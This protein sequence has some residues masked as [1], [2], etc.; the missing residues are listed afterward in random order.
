MPNLG[1]SMRLDSLIKDWEG[2]KAKGEKDRR[3]W[4]SQ[5][6]NIEVGIGLKSDGWPGA[7]YWLERQR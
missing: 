6:L 7:D 1:R 5:H 4:A 3:I 2:E